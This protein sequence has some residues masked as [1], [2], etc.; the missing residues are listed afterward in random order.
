MKPFIK[1]VF[2]DKATPE[3][4]HHEFRFPGGTVNIQRTTGDEYWVHIQVVLPHQKVAEVKSLSKVGTIVEGRMDDQYG[5]E[6]LNT[7]NINHIAIL[8]STEEHDDGKS[9]NHNQ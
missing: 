4:E 2:G 5:V 3:P 1:E 9:N 6:A 8:I 7:E